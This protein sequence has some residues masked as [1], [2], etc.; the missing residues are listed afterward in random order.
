ML[1]RIPTWVAFSNDYDRLYEATLKKNKQLDDETH[2]K[3]NEAKY[4]FLE[5]QLAI[6]KK[7]GVKCMAD[8]GTLLGIIRDGDLIRNDTDLQ[9]FGETLNK[10]FFDD[11]DKTFYAVP[12]SKQS[13]KKLFDENDDYHELLYVWLEDLDKDGNKITFKSPG[14][15]TVGMFGDLMVSYPFKDGKRILRWPGWEVMTYDQKH[16]D[17]INTVSFKGF[18]VPVPSSTTEYIQYFYGEG[19]KTPQSRFGKYTCEFINRADAHK[20]TYSLKDG[21][22]KF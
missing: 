19:W 20:Y 6:C 1:N 7:H 21:K 14:G 4:K 17:K 5:K 2:K 9:I 12:S 22:Y 16:A 3:Y 13:F 15:A 10:D 8:F 11:L 18:D